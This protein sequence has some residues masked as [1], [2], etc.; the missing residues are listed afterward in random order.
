MH[1]PGRTT[2]PG[3]WPPAASTLTSR[4]R[5]RVP[6]SSLTTPIPKHLPWSELNT[7]TS[8]REQLRALPSI[9]R[10]APAF[11]LA[12]APPSPHELF[13]EWLRVAIAA[14]VPEP[15]AVTLST[16]APGGQPDARVLI[17]KNVGDDGGYE[18]ATSNRSAKG[19]Q[20]AA[21]PACAVSV[22]WSP[23]ARAVRI[24]GTAERAS[25]QASAADFLARSPEARAIALA[26]QR[27]SVTT[28]ND[29]RRQLVAAALERVTDDPNLVDP[30]WTIWRVHPASVEFWQG[31]PDRD[32]IRLRY[33]LADGA[34]TRSRL[35]A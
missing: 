8:I 25:E 6:R 28:D 5:A 34:W 19:Q 14:G 30:A 12:A 3:T 23:L 27:A 11:D 9:T 17:L 2:N 33:D 29:E 22:Y 7:L 16:V 21:N 1:E 26:A 4:N 20:L 24:R 32:H 10:T 35:W 31:D 18:I 15:H 13:I